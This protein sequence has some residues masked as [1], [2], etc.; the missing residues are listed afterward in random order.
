MA[1]SVHHGLSEIRWAPSEAF[2]ESDAF[3]TSPVREAM[4]DAKPD[5]LRDRFFTLVEESDETDDAGRGAGARSPTRPATRA[6]RRS[7]STPTR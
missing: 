6:R 7:T 3:A 5:D 4:S 1:G 2:L